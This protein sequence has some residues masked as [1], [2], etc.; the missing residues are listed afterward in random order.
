MDSHQDLPHFVAA[1]RAALSLSQKDLAQTLGYTNQAISK[2]EKGDSSISLSVIPSLADLLH[3]SVEDLL[4]C[5][6]TP[7]AAFCKNEPFDAKRI[8]R[9]L[10][11]LRKH[12]NLSQQQEAEAL[13]VAKRTIIHYE[14]GSSLPSLSILDRLIDYYQISYHAFFY[15]VLYPEIPFATHHSGFKSVIVSLAILLLGGAGLLTGLLLSQRYGS[16]ASTSEASAP[17]EAS[18]DTS[19]TTQTVSEDTETSSSSSSSDSSS[20]TSH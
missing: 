17:S 10:Y 11:C 13:G 4:S 3:L 16:S 15:E 12:A 2:F 8:E 20:S 7:S 9:N 18:A 6:T 1:R 14:K 19:E 5:Q